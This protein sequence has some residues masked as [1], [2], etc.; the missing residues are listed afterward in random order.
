MSRR[1]SGPL[2]RATKAEPRKPADP[3]LAERLGSGIVR[4]AAIIAGLTMLSRILGL[5]RTLVFSQTV[6][7]GCLG[8]AYVTAYQVPNLITELVLGGA[9]TSAMVPVLARSAARAADDP[10]ERDR[11]G[12]ILS[13][14]L[15]WTVAILVPLSL[16][17]GAVAR[18]VASLLIPVNAHSGCA[19]AD[20]VS[21]TSGM[22]EV[23]APQVFL[24]GLSV[25]LFGLLQAYRRFTGPAL[26]PVVASLVLITSYAIFVP[27]NGGRALSSTPLAAELV[28]SVGATLSI[29][30]LVLVVLVPARRLHLKIRLTF[31]LPRE[32]ARFAGGMAAVGVV[33]FIFIDLANLV[34]IVLANGRGDTGAL[35]LYNYAWLVFNAVFAV[36]V[37]SVVTSAFPVMSVGEGD[38]LDRVCAG[39]TRAVLL[40]SWLGGAV[41]AAIAVP[42]AHVLARQPDQVGQ[43]ILG[44]ALFAPGMAGLAVVTNLSRVLFALRRLKV[45]AVALSGSWLIVMAVDAA[46]A[47]LVPPRLVVGALALGSTL[48][49]TIVAVP[50][51]IAIRRIRG[52]AAT[53]GAGR[54][55]ATGAGAGAAGAAAGLAAT[56]AL[57]LNGRLLSGVMAVG[58]AGCAVIVFGVFCYLIGGADVR[59]IMPRLWRFARTRLLYGH[60]LQ[61]KLAAALANESFQVRSRISGLEGGEDFVRRGGLA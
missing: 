59:T 57:P 11:V 55:M 31:W 36:L 12:Q 18:P 17:L 21:V 56:M 39:S 35:V 4:G 1:E 32:V 13:A 45:A 58:S 52:R 30:A 5:V 27:L 33:E 15:T 19:R 37:L 2:A 7:A 10:A 34:V 43:L 41:I 46:L 51:M 47:E 28:L 60:H 40:M 16:V 48:G 61:L 38:E 22:L 44:F 26:A 9:L 20:M 24:Y 25:V 14:L 6:G 23:F 53:A 29:A 49:Q 50:L 54:A 8:T 42:A 3:G